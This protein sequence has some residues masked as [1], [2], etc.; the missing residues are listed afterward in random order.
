MGGYG[1]LKLA[2]RCPDRFAAAASLSGALDVVGRGVVEVYPEWATTFGD[3][4]GARER[5]DDLLD[6]VSQ[7]DPHRMPTLYAWCGEQDFLLGDSRAFRDAC[8]AAGVELTYC[9]SA[10]DHSWEDWDRQIQ[11]VLDWLPLRA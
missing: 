7:A 3:A 1:A 8:Q 4:A 11:E 6:L 10:G 9:E 5:G 2:L